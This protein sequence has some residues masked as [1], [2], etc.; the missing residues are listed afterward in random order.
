MSEFDYSSFPPGYYQEV[1]ENGPKIQR[2]WHL[3][4]FSRIATILSAAPARKLLDIGCFAGSFLGLLS[5]EQAN[6]QVG[7][8]IIESQ[9][10]FA[11]ARFGNQF[12]S[13]KFIKSIN[14]LSNAGDLFD[15]VTLIEVIEHLSVEELKVIFEEIDK[16]LIS[17]GRLVITTPN[18]L[19]FWPL[20]EILIKMSS[21]VN[22]Q[23]QHLTHFYFPNIF[24]K[25]KTIAPQ[26]FEKYT[27]ELK[28]SSH[29]LAPF[30]AFISLKFSNRLSQFINPKR[31]RNPFGPLIIIVL[32]KKL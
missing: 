11:Q 12:R 4:K 21:G 14:D 7:V 17:D 10:K 24:E 31:W 29:F 19:S 23:E 18:Y 6:E 20:L 28:T 26:V 16:I 30:L 5:P 2:A 9:I 13:F 8:D 25:L 27:L 15:V 3:Q 22:Y 1:M 32:R